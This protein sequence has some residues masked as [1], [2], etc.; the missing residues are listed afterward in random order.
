MNNIQH[1]DSLNAQWE[2]PLKDFIAHNL[3]ASFSSDA[4]ISI[5]K[6]RGLIGLLALFKQKAIGFVLCTPKMLK[7]KLDSLQRR[8]IMIYSK[9][10]LVHRWIVLC[11][12]VDK[13]FKNNRQ[14][15]E[16][17]LLICQMVLLQRRK[18]RFF[19][20]AITSPYEKDVASSL[21]SSNE[22]KDDNFISLRDC[23]P[24][25]EF[26]LR[27]KFMPIKSSPHML[28]EIR[29]ERI[30]LGLPDNLPKMLYK[31]SNL[32]IIEIN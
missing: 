15:F 30:L 29:L 16:R 4:L 1:D 26:W 9:P 23:L 31:G 10:K 21:H 5:I 18:A 12:K 28:H 19:E 14:E 24:A 7:N 13:D 32:D 2:K 25:Q 11:L 27:M 8:E 17:L 20:A 6:T 3:A 22:L